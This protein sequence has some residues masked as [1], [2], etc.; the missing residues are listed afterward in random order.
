M[1]KNMSIYGIGG[2][3][4]K[5][6]QVLLLPVYTR[7]L[8][9]ADYGSLELVYMVAAAIAILYGF[10]ISSG[11]LRCYYDSKEQKHRDLVLGSAFWFTF[12]CAVLFGLVLLLSASEIA[13]SIFEFEGGELFIT[14]I[15]FS[16]AI[17]A[18]NYIFYNL[19]MVREKAGSYV[20][21]NIVTM[22]VTMGVTIYFVVFL[23]WS[24]RGI[25]LAQIIAFG[26]EFI[27]L[28][29]L[30]FRRTIFAYSFS[31]VREMLHFSVPLIP[32]QLASFIL[33]MADRFFLQEYRTLDE[34][35]LYSLGYKFAAIMPLLV[36][37]PFRAFG[38]HIF[39][40]IDTPE[41]CKRTLAD[42]SRYYLAGSLF[43]AL[44]ISMFSREVI[45]VMSDHS[46]HEGYRV[47]FLLC[48]SYV[49]YGLNSLTG[50]AINIVKK[51]WIISVTW[52]IA[53]GVNIALNFVLIPTYGM[54]GA[55]AATVISYL[56]VAVGRLVII[57]YVYPIRFAY[58]AFAGI[59][60]CA[61]LVYALSTIAAS[62]IV[63]PMTIKTILLAMFLLVV[64]CSTYFTPEER[65]KAV[66]ALRAFFVK[67]PASD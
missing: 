9:P 38:P 40:L 62:G 36:I 25:L 64:F 17:K 7:V 55:A 39:S 21:I 67:T 1:L 49:F 13:G 59:C 57:N 37:E 58:A 26:I 24:V 48:L 8:K 63:I 20:S 66:E 31:A 43:F 3:A 54:M 29:V 6:I 52:I 60:I 41:E 5:A 53:A 27:I 14:L 18:H 56:I 15:A 12:F 50:Y 32:L 44:A 4:A 65:S 11:Y 23:R 42:F 19:L 47:V 61:A 30:L 10:M 33:T 16:T 46:Y 45:M 51:N 34:V 2:I 22:L 35:G 28:S